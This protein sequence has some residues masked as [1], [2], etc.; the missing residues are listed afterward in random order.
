MTDES[1][2]ANIADE[3][4][5][6]RQAL[7]AAEALADLLLFADSISRSY[8]AVFHCLRAL[9]FSRGVEPKTHSG[10]IHLFNSEFV[11][12]GLFASTHNRLLAGMKGARELADYDAAASFSR[13][14][15]RGQIADAHA[16]AAEVRSFLS[17]EGWVD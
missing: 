4:E 6:G 2:R 7:A 15:A 14:D 17:G 12:R 8:Y 11:R 9:L 5:R 16:F 10:A 13:D 3:L 1:R